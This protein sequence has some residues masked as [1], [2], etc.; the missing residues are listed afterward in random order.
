MCSGILQTSSC[1]SLNSGKALK[2][3]KSGSLRIV[4][5][6]RSKSFKAIRRHSA[7]FFPSPLHQNNYRIINC[8]DITLFICALSREQITVNSDRKLHK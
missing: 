5:N 1:N 6:L 4:P 7:A 2:E 8:V 3:A